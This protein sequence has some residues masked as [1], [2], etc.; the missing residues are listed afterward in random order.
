MSKRGSRYG[1]IM[2]RK[3]SVENAFV[4]RID[5]TPQTGSLGSMP[6][7]IKPLEVKFII[8]KDGDSKSI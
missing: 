8:V 3:K 1:R 7:H 2:A 6:R 5:R 4:H